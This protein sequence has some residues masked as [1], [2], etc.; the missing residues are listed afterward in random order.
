MTPSRPDAVAYLTGGLSDNSVPSGVSPRGAG[1]KFTSEG[2]VLPWRGN[3][4]ICHVQRGSQEHAALCEVQAALRESPLSCH[5]AYLPPASFHMTVFQL[6]SNGSDWPKEVPQ[7]ASLA[8]ATDVLTRQLAGVSVPKVFAVTAHE[9]YG[10]F[11]I[12]MSGACVAEES[13]LRQTRR[14]LRDATGITPHD[15]DGY[16]FHITLGYLLRWLDVDEAT[17]MVD[18]S[19]AVFARFGDQLQ[20]IKLGPLEF[21]TFENMHHFK[22]VNFL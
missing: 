20:N 13:K 6:I 18:L 16:V 21:C 7:D 5:F 8:T 15:F 2:L 17:R 11:S 22:Q 4:I 9:I 3:T 12:T 19:Q 10:G 14:L 1:A